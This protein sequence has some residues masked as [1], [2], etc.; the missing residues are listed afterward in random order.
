MRFFHASRCRRLMLLLGLAL[1]AGLVLAR[2]PAA[3]AHAQQVRSSPDPG[4]SVTSP[5]RSVDVWFSERVTPKVS[6][7]AVYD[8]S[9]HRVDSAPSVVD[10]QDAK[11]LSV[12]L[13]ALVPGFYTVIWSNLS[14]DD[15]HPNKGGFGFT[16]LPPGAA[17]ASGSTTVAANAVAAGSGFVNPLTPGAAPTTGDHL[18]E[19]SDLVSSWAVFLALVVAGGGAVFVLVCLRPVLLTLGG[20]GDELARRTGR[21]FACIAVVAGLGGLVAGVVSFFA[22]LALATTTPFQLDAVTS[23]LAT[24]TGL[25]WL[26]GEV[27]FVM[28]AAA[29]GRALRRGETARNSRTTLLVLAGSGA[30]GIT[31]QAFNSHLAAGH[32]ARQWPLSVAPLVVHLLAVGLWVGGLGYAALV[33]WPIWRDT[34][35]LL[36]AAIGARVIAR[37]S[38]FA[39]AGVIAIAVSGAYVAVVMVPSLSDLIG[40]DYGRALSLKGLL[41]LVLIGLGALNRRT[42]AQLPRV[43]PAH[44]IATAA[45]GGR[46]LLGAMRLEF[47]LALVVLLA[48]ATMIEVGPPSRLLPASAVSVSATVNLAGLSAPAAA[49]LPGP[50]PFDATTTVQGLA[51]DLVVDPPVAGTN[52]T[53]TV[54]A[55]GAG[56]APV[57]NAEVKLWLTASAM[58][59]GTQVLTAGA[60]APGQYRVTAPA[61]GV[62]GPWQVQVVVRRDNLPDVQTT[63]SVPIS[64]PKVAPAPT[65]VATTATEPVHAELTLNPNPPRRGAGTATL[66]LSGVGGRPVDGVQASAVWLMPQ[67]GHSVST[68]FVPVAGRPG[69]Y[70]SPVSFIMSGAWDAQ[71]SLKSPAGP[72]TGL[73]FAFNVQ[74]VGFAPRFDLPRLLAG[75]LAVAVGLAAVAWLV[76]RRD[77]RL[78]VRA[79]LAAAG[80]LLVLAGGAVGIASIQPDPTAQALTLTNPIPPSAQSIL[81]GQAVYTERCLNCHGPAGKGDGMVATTLNPPPADL[82]VHVNAHPDGQLFEW[83]T[84]GIPGSAMPSFHSLLTD[85][86]RWDVLNYLHTLARG[87]TI[88][89]PQ[90]VATVSGVAGAVVYPQ[91]NTLVRFEPATARTATIATLPAGSAALQ[92]ATSP[93]GQ[94]YAVDV[95]FAPASGAAPYTDLYLV[96]AATGQARLLLSHTAAGGELGPPAWSPD[97]TEV[98]ASVQAS[99]QVT[100]TWLVRV[101]RS[102]GT[103]QRLIQGAFGPT[104]SADGQT[105]VFVKYDAGGQTVQLWRSGPD[106]SA[107]RPIPG[108]RFTGILHPDLSPDGQ[109]VAF[110]A[111]GTP[112]GNPAPTGLLRWL[113]PPNASAHGGPWEVW[114]VPLAGGTAVQRSS[115]AENGSELAWSP[116]GQ[117]IGLTGDLGIYLIHA[118]DDRAYLIDGQPGLG[119]AWVKGP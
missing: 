37:F 91:G 54:T 45:G 58:D 83:I 25:L 46:R 55:S 63:L 111:V 74:D 39:L 79:G 20:A 47:G 73:H 116:D 107:A 108:S 33:L 70:Q 65:A 100:D 112:Q 84:D 64:T 44:V 11:H 17:T 114:T 8:A 38:K 78:P 1:V 27:A 61:F 52:S 15:G 26:A 13:P 97:S 9:Q 7:I 96:Q 110:T 99:A 22:K 90:P 10:P 104:L 69:S 67:H 31:L 94:W 101:S 88:P 30:L 3:S 4:A 75:L 115:I 53:L 85:Q 48:A 87:A 23:T 59:L 92:P 5:P 98:Y 40:S 89:A 24:R 68:R 80:A 42:L 29:G 62:A 34:D 117:W 60:I 56:G 105:L 82:T 57:N 76:R 6:S 19:L 16:V 51:L 103:P 32:V 109:T 95:Q 66:L 102:G 41:L 113:E 28:A 106:G 72:S 71:L 49:Q 14:A 21:R 36:R 93:D 2:P 12:A 81:R 18:A 43:S 77:R 50:T 118:A 119:L 86:Q 35:V